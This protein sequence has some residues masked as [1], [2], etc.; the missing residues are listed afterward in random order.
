[1]A[2]AYAAQCARRGLQPGPVDDYTLQ[3]ALE[4]LSLDGSST[5]PL[6]STLRE[7]GFAKAVAKYWFCEDI[8]G[9]AAGQEVARFTPRRSF[10]PEELGNHP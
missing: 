9:L 8:N 10:R 3:A 4:Q 5:A 2:D 7:G 1:M 6:C